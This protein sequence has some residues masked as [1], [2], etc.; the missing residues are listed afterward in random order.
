MP[1]GD[2]AAD[3]AKADALVLRAAEANRQGKRAEAIARLVEA[4]ILSPKDAGIRGALGRL[5][6][7]DGQKLRALDEFQRAHQTDPG[8][9]DS[10]F[11]LAAVLLDLGRAAEAK[12]LLDALAVQRPDDPRIQKL[13]A[14]ARGETG[15]DQAALRAL[16]AVAKATPSDARAQAELGTALARD[17]QFDAAAGALEIA[18]RA[19]PEDATAQLRLGTALARSGRHAEAE[20][21]LRAAVRLAPGDPRGWE[22]LGVLHED[23]G[24]VS[25]AIEAYES[26]LKNVNNGDPEGKVRQR[27]EAL[28]ALSRAPSPPSGR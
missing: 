9:Q 25:G 16:Q 21:A 19:H 4:T 1:Q 24:D 27:I 22:N 12:T 15:D 26:L 5:L 17:G 6:H 10:A 8:H 7:E 28:R 18:A 23:K 14:T 20:V 11:G 2:A 13:L 3:Q